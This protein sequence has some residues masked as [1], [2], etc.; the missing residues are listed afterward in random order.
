MKVRQ[1]F[2]LEHDSYLPLVL[3]YI[4]TAEYQEGAFGQGPRVNR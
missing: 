3:L 2:S 4:R 1:L